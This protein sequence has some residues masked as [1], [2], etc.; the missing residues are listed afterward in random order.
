[1]EFLGLKDQQAQL[2]QWAHLECPANLELVDPVPPAIPE[3][4]ARV[5]CQ[6]EMALLGQWVRKDQ[7]VTLGLQVSEHQENQARMVTQVCLD[8]WVLKAHRDQLVSPAQ[9]AGQVLAKQVNT[10]YQVAEDPPVLQEPLVRKESQAQLV[11]LVSQVLVVLMAKLVHRV[12]QDTMVREADRDLKATLVWSVHQVQREP[13]VN[14][15]LKVSLENQVLQGQQVL[16]EIQGIVVL[17]V[18]RAHRAMMVPQE[19][20]VQMVPQDQKDTQASQEDQEKVVRMEGQ[21][22]WAKLGP[23]V[24]QVPLELRAIQVF[25]AHLAQLA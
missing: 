5:V 22:L 3:N 10:D 11:L 24:H 20:L 23:P 17:R 4:Q 25:Q 19:S 14:R 12:Q 1:M 7:R 15:E 18:K 2:D 9:L 13:R 16:Q 6:E 8:L 21:D